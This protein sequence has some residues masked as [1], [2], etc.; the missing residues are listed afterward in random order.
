MQWMRHLWYNVADL[1][2]VSDSNKKLVGI[3]LCT[4]AGYALRR[5]AGRQVR[6]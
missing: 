4:S 3:L 6:L 2:L 5:D 1:Y